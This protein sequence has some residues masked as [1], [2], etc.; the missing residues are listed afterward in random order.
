[1][2]CKEF[3]GNIFKQVRGHLFTPELNGFK[4]CFSTRLVL[5]ACI[6]MAS[7]TVIQHF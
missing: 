5:I 2:I 7:S 3:V 4:Y 1:M 6:K